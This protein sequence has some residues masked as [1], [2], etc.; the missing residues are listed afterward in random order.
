MQHACNQ[1]G[2]ESQAWRVHV[3]VSTPDPTRPIDQVVTFFLGGRFSAQIPRCAP[4][5]PCYGPPVLGRSLVTALL[6]SGCAAPSLSDDETNVEAVERS[7]SSDPN[8]TAQTRTVLANL[9][10]VDQRVIVGQQDAD[11]SNRSS[12]GPV[13][14]PDIVKVTGQWPALVSYEMSMGYPHAT[15]G[16]DA[17]AFRQGRG[18]LRERVLEQH[19]R[20]VLSSFVWHIRCPKAR[21]TDNDRFA[22][23]ECPFD[24]NLSELLERKANGRPGRHFREWRAI[25]DE[26]AELL[27]SLKD[28]RG[29]LVPVQLRPFH[30]FNGAWFWWGSL[31]APDVY[32]QAWREMVTYLRDGRGLHSVIWVY[33]PAGP[34]ETGFTRQY[35]GDAYVDVIA[36]DRYDKDDGRFGRQF[37]A[38]LDVI[39][40]FARAHDKI[41][42]V[43]EVGRSLLGSRPDSTWFTRL[44][45]S[46]SSRS[47]AYVALWR[48]APWEKFLPEPG[49]GP[50]A[51]DLRTFATDSATLVAGEHDLFTP[52]AR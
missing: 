52:L 19:R 4:P 12:Y 44:L 36:F 28:E 11:I 25:L 20:G 51:D 35:P 17:A 22:P 2:S 41:A 46:L 27:W 34:S 50:I 42:A 48:N 45:A 14:V 29:Q 47:F 49:D 24:Y 6:I 39:Q 31:N 33:S 26:L 1:E 9:A 23:W 18:F 13:V 8:A 32:A 37:A 30:E 21:P 10:S 15:N 43:S 40:S 3:P 38:D 7:R 5:A 16:F